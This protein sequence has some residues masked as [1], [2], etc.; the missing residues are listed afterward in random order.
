ME[1]NLNERKKVMEDTSKNNDLRQS[2]E[3]LKQVLLLLD[4]IERR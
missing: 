2:I 1:S 4:E 3:L